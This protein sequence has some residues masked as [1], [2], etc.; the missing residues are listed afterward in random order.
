MLGAV[1]VVWV[2]V[3]LAFCAQLA[4]F[5]VCFAFGH[6]DSVKRVLLLVDPRD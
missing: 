2:A 4:Y 6:L 5:V 1:G 3:D